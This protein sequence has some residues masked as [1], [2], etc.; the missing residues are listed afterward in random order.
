ML[1]WLK[2]VHR[3]GR[4]PS[5]MD[6]EIPR[7]DHFH[8]DEG[9]E[10]PDPV[11]M[12]PPV[13]FKKQPSMVENIRNMVRSEMLQREAAAAGFETF[14]EAED[15][16]PEDDGVP[17]P[18]TA[19]EAVFDPLVPQPSQEPAPA[20]QGQSATPPAQSSGGSPQGGPAGPA[21]P[22]PGSPTPAAPAPAPSGQPASS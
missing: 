5:D 3:K 18:H 17:L 14:E 7:Q 10:I 15:F 22:A 13:G 20:P 21:G 16:G 1:D 11:P 8:T 12:A 9:Y 19:Y 6:Q 2:N 4:Q